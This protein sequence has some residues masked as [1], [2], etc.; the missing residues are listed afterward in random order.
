MSLITDVMAREIDPDGPLAKGSVEDIE[1]MLSVEHEAEV[2]SDFHINFYETHMEGTTWQFTRSVHPA[3]PSVVKFTYDE[4]EDAEI[5]KVILLGFLCEAEKFACKKLELDLKN[6][7]LEI[8]KHIENEN[9][10]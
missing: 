5:I 3:H 9:E 6:N 10:M 7:G 1:F 8:N 4:Y 2:R